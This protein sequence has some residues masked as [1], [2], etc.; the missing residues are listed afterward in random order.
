MIL[1]K[2]ELGR[3]VFGLGRYSLR[4]RLVFLLAAFGRQFLL[5]L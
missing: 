2:L 5:T 1:C 3:L 4:G